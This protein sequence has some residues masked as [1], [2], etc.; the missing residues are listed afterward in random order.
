MSDPPVRPIW[1][2]RSTTRPTRRP[3]ERPQRRALAY[4]AGRDVAAR[5]PA[6]AELIPCDL[7]TNRA[8]CLMLARKRIISPAAHQAIAAG[9]DAIEA[10]WRAGA[11]A[12]DPLLEDVHMNI[13]RAVAGRVGEEAAG[14]MHTARSRN[15]QSATDMRLWLRERLLGRLEGVCVTI[16]ALARLGERHAATIAPAGPTAS[17]R[18]RRRWA[19]GRSPT[20]GPWRATARRSWRSGR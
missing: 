5:P 17:R 3:G 12:L 4:C 11:F 10:Q 7:W 6:D 13:E 19:I 2:K 18:C 16:E 15:D 9:L 8:H 1:T 20:A 14:M